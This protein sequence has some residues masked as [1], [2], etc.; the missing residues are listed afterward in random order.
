MSAKHRGAPQSFSDG[1][2]RHIEIDWS[3]LYGTM[4][5]AVVRLAL[6][7]MKRLP[8]S[9]SLRPLPPL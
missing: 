2:K 8:L 1:R 6:V 9:P 7:S 5:R 3:L 4:L